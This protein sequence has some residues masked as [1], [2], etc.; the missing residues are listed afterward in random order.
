MRI[1]E[2]ESRLRRRLSESLPGHDA[3]LELSGYKRPD[4]EAALRQ[5]PP[6]RESAVLAL[7]YAKDQLAHTV[8]MLRPNYDGVHS[9]Q[10]AF[11]G[12]RREP[13]DTDLVATALR[14]F[15]EET[16]AAPEEAE[17]LGSL[18]PVYIPPSRSLVTPYVAIAREAGPFHPDPH[19]VAE[20]MEV[21]LELLLR[22]DILKRREQ[23]IAIMGRTVEIP[24]FD[25]RGHVVWGAT[26]MMI[27]E[28]RELL[29]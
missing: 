15:E 23:H 2:A 28:L 22:D 12:G 9:G 11:P 14:E 17:I 29:R 4:L 3:F 5:D 25:V 6:P 26:A 24:Y 13:G 21:P 10:V 16:G 1:E 7:L 27:A 18:T 8:L 19:E 20:L